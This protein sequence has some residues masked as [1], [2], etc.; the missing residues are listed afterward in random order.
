[1][2]DS[3]WT[4]TFFET[5]LRSTE[6]IKSSTYVQNP[7][8]L[9]QKPS[10]SIAGTHAQMLPR[11]IIHTRAINFVVASSKVPVRGT[12]RAR[13][14]KHGATTL[15]SF[16]PAN[17]LTTAAYSFVFAVWGCD[18]SCSSIRNL[19]AGALYTATKMASIGS[20]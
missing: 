20:P 3:K 1:M 16:R 9:S 4:H 6:K 12:S 2:N 14:V 17:F 5:R 8:A 19:S 18:Q 10:K 15:L 11:N 7:P 13:H